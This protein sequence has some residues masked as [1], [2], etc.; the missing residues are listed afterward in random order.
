[1]QF[2]GFELMSAEI[3][4][5]LEACIEGGL[6]GGLAHFVPG[7]SRVEH[8]DGGVT[9][10][11][12]RL[13]LFSVFVAVADFQRQGIVA[14]VSFD[15]NAEVNFHTVSFLK[16]H[17]AIPAFNALNLVVGGEMGRQ[18]VHRNGPRKSGFSTVPMN[19]PL[20]G[21]DDLVEGL[22]RLEFILHGLKGSP[23]DVP[24]ISPI[25]QVGFFHH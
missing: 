10:F 6:S 4:D 12:G 18:V 1:M 7:R 19:E 8:F 3:A 9:G 25:L 23:S 15:V 20:S 14:N 16:H 21:F 2:P 5:G 22:S 11:L 13:D 24:C 17:V